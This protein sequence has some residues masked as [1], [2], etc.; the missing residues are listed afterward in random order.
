MQTSLSERASVR[1][2]RETEKTNSNSGGGRTAFVVKTGAR[3]R[4]DVCRCEHE[5]RI[6]GQSCVV[7]VCVR[8]QARTRLGMYILRD[9]NYVSRLMF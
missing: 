9:G 7:C 8:A 1:T 5:R 4:V 2:L 3:G 6:P